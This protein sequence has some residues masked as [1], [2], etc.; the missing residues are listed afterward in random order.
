MLI[1]TDIETT[2]RDVIT[3]LPWAKE[4]AG[5]PYIA[6]SPFGARLFSRLV[7]AVCT[8]AAGK[9]HVAV[10]GFCRFTGCSALS[11]S[12]SSLLCLDFHAIISFSFPHA[13]P[14][15]GSFCTLSVWTL[16]TPERKLD[17]CTATAY[18]EIHDDNSKLSSSG[19]E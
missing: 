12:L 10:L 5:A 17:L 13:N 18:L 15:W 3:Y 4:L 14:A 8:D 16:V 1:A 2:E 11:L 7:V 19:H 9:R 6:E